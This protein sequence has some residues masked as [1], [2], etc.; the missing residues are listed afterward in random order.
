MDKLL[1]R[2][3][4]REG[5]GLDDDNESDGKIIL[6]FNQESHEVYM[7]LH[8]KVAKGDTDVDWLSVFAYRAARDAGFVNQFLR[9]HNAKLWVQDQNGSPMTQINTQTGLTVG[10]GAPERRRILF[11]RSS[12]EDLIEGCAIGAGEYTVNGDATRITFNTL[13]FKLYPIPPI[14]G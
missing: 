9:D 4:L 13:I 2:Q 10:L 3:D 1:G 7:H 5:F 6:T 14:D 8:L 11:E 12:A